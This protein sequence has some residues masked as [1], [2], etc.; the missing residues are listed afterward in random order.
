MKISNLH[1]VHTFHGE[2]EEFSG[3]YKDISFTKEGNKYFTVKLNI[4]GGY[5]LSEHLELPIAID[6]LKQHDLV[7][8][9]I[10]TFIKDDT[11]RIF[12]L[13]NIN[14]SAKLVGYCNYYG[15]GD[16]WKLYVNSKGDVVIQHLQFPQKDI[17]IRFRDFPMDK[18]FYVHL[19]CLIYTV[20]NY[21]LNSQ[22]EIRMVFNKIKDKVT[23]GIP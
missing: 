14:G 8:R 10:E 5:E 23:N 20:T 18:E 17:T 12:V 6:H 16:D 21:K 11:Q 9:F 15:I 22:A 7:F 2:S 19:S 4:L 13:H 1:I 3:L